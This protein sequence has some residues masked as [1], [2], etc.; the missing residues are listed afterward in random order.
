[1]QRHGLNAADVLDVVEAAIGGRRI[2]TT[3]EGQ[4]RYAV[5]VRYPRERRDTVAAMENILIPT[6]TGQQVPLADLTTFTYQRGP[7]MI[8]SENAR[9]V[10]YITFDTVDGVAEV[11]AAETIQRVLRENIQARRLTVPRGVG[12]QL[13]GQFRNEQCANQRLMLLIPAALSVMFLLLYLQFRSLLMASLIFTG[14]AVAFSGGFL[15]LW[16]YGRTW[17]LDVEIAGE[18]L[19]H[20][21][22]V[23]PVNLSTAIWVGFLALFGIATDDGVV[24]G[25]YLQQTFG[26]REPETPEGIRQAVVT[27]GS[28]RVRACL[29][30]TATTL[31]ALLPVLT[32]TGRGSDIMAPMAIPIFGGMAIEVLT[33]LVVPVL[34]C[35][36]REKQ[37]RLRGALSE[38]ASES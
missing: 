14:V 21:F 23:G 10:A 32:S 28:R 8:K 5:R 19:R 37:Q 24:M 16:L 25:T 17:F 26:R 34:Y 33:M 18:S 11:E 4:E 9:K 12:Y 35:L 36:V 31:L 6:P 13:A 2:T 15:L 38:H 3:I 27:A 20:L 1:M 29:M 22:Q 30:T 7:Q